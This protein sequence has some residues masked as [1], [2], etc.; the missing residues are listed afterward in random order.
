VKGFTLLEVVVVC[1]IV[2]IIAAIAIPVVQRSKERALQSRSIENMRQ[3]YIAIEG[4]SQD[5][6]TAQYGSMTAM[7]LPDTPLSKYLGASVA[8]LYPPKRRRGIEY[9]YYPIPPSLD[10]RNPSWTQYTLEHEGQTVLLADAWFNPENSRSEFKD[11][12]MD[13]SAEKFLIGITLEGS[14]RQKRAA[15]NLSLTWWDR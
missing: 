4:Y 12:L 5:Y 11:Y 3:L 10:H 13:P 2:A 8:D 7:G 1:A 6:E 15:G 9:Y 14:I